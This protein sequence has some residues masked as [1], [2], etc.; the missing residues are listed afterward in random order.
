LKPVAT[1]SK[2]G[3]LPPDE[4]PSVAYGMMSEIMP[5]FRGGH[6]KELVDYIQR[7][8]AWPKE[9]GKRIPAEGRV[10]VSFTVDTTGQVQNAKVVKGFHPLFDAAVLEVVRKLDGFKPGLQYDKPVAVS[11]TLPITFTLKK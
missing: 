5:S 1:P 8:V 4:N 9:N 11:F 2:P 10:F 7:Q 3:T 6:N